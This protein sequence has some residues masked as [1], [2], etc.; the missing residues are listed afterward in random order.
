M[1]GE[2]VNQFICA[3]PWP[4]NRLGVGGGEFPAFTLSLYNIL[5]SVSQ[6]V[7]WES[8]KKES[9]FYAGARETLI[10]I[11]RWLGVIYSLRL[12]SVN[13]CDWCIRRCRPDCHKDSNSPIKLCARTIPS[14]KNVG[15]SLWDDHCETCSSNFVFVM[16]IILFSKS[17]P[18]CILR[19]FVLH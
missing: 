13:R 19:M 16:K 12:E 9:W 14:N 17:T 3:I 6:L 10:W 8:Y 4:I 11:Q 7:V 5:W 1:R 18:R 2:K 15:R